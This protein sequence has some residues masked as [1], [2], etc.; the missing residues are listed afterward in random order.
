MLLLMLNNSRRI[1]FLP[2]FHGHDTARGAIFL[3]GFRMYMILAHT[4]QVLYLILA[5][6]LIFIYFE[7]R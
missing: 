5:F 1:P 2:D 4:N 3:L 6:A 7:A